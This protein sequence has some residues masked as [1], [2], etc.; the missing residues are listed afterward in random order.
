MYEKFILSRECPLSDKKVMNNL[1]VE[2]HLRGG[3]SDFD[4][5][6]WL[7]GKCSAKIM[8]GTSPQEVLNDEQIKNK[9]LSQVAYNMSL[10]APGKAFGSLE[11]YVKNK[12]VIPPALT[13]D[14]RREQAYL[15]FQANPLDI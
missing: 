14:Q 2:A 5:L 9:V 8:Q 6:N 15:L 13:E 12:G 7:I 1:W 11:A 3:E 4:K 10:N